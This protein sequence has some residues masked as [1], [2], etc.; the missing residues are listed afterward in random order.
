MAA[1]IKAFATTISTST[2]L[3]AINAATATGVTGFAVTLNVAN[4]ATTNQTAYVD[5]TRYNGTT[6]Y[7]LV[8]QA[9]VYPG[10]ALSVISKPAVQAFSSGYQF[11]AA[12][13]STGTPIDC[14]LSIVEIT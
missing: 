11:Y 10:S 4:T 14:N 1:T 2:A 8:R 3:T 13:L 6:H 5:V 7:Y 12:I 9:P